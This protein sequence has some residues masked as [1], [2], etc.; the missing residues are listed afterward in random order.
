MIV[1][2]ASLVIVY[3][4]A[5]CIVTFIQWRNTKRLFDAYDTLQKDWQET[6]KKRQEE[7]NV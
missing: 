5:G 6:V 1:I 4:V 3:I 7:R 2:V